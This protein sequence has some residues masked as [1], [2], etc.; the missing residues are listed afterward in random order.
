PSA[1]NVRVSTA[2]I[3]RRIFTT[4]QNGV[5]PN[6]N[7]ANLL[8]PTGNAA[9]LAWTR[10]SLW[11][12]SVGSTDNLF[13]APDATGTGAAPIRGILDTA[14]G[15]DALTTVARVQLAVPG[16]CQGTVAADIH[17]DCTSLTAGVPLARAKREAREIVLAYLAGAMVDRQ[18]G[19]PVR[20]AGSGGVAANRARLQY[21]IRPWIMAESTLAA[22]GVV[23]P[24]LL[25]GPKN[26]AGAVGVNEYKD[27]RDGVRTSTGAPVNGLINGLGLRNPDRLA[28]AT[29]QSIKDAAAAD[30]T[31]KPVMSVVYH[32]TNQGLHAFRAGPCPTPPAVAGF[33]TPV[34]GCGVSLEDTTRREMGGEELWAFVP[35]D[36]LSKLPA[37]TKSQSRTNKQYLLASPVR[38]TDVFVPGG[39]NFGGKSF[40]GVWRTL[41][42]FGRGQG[43]KYYT[44]LDITAAGPFT[45]HSLSTEL[46]PLVWSRGNPDTPTGV[47]TAGGPYNNTTNGVGDYNAYLKMG[48]TWSLPGV[49]FVTAANY[50]TARSGV[51]GRNFVLF[52]GSGYSDTLTE[53]KT[54]YVLDALTGDVVRNF[55]IPDGRPAALPPPNTV[56][57][58]FLVAPP[59]VYAEDSD[60]NSPS[61]YRFIGNPISAKAKTVYFGDLHSRIWRYDANS[62]AAAP[63][64]FFQANTATD[65]NQPFAT[66][67]SVLQNRPDLAAAGDVLVYAEAGHDRRAPVPADVRGALPFQAYA[68]KDPGGSGALVFTR[69]F[70]TNYRGTTQPA[71]TFVVSPPPGAPAP[72]V[73]Y[74]GTKFGSTDCVGTFDSILIALKGVVSS[75]GAPPE[76]AFD[77]RATGDD[78]FIE[79]VGKKINAI[80]VSGEGSLVVD[81]GLNAQN[82]PP[83][84]GVAVVAETVAGSTSLVSVG[85]VPG[86][87]QYKHLSATTVPYRIG[88]SV[89]RTEY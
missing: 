25:A 20:T 51:N 17:P 60:G 81:Q 79:F 37:L 13:V 88:S 19:L 61:G 27:Y 23:T 71:T 52:T 10:V 33:A 6:Y 26:T 18:N 59:V 57:T 64:V 44:A 75:A 34:A 78:A 30:L 14:M 67:V 2:K 38:F 87:T 5:N 56:L 72:V 1:N 39:G 62:P 73:F 16:A 77:L 22:P 15:F 28:G 45:R 89:C 11:P 29:A 12:P 65:G 53:G 24:P 86:S 8:D 63:T 3:K 76:A 40:A 36:L 47:T 55:D 69:A 21:V 66:A 54:F 82:P 9:A 43:G 32:A 84:P 46:P 48:E 68:L 83:P 4:T 31:L 70:E 35:Y 58:N 80:R 49:G 74:A 41:L 50:T 7:V 85:L 42:Y